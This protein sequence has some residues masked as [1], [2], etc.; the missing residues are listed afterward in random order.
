MSVDDWQRRL[1]ADPRGTLAELAQSLIEERPEDSRLEDLFWRALADH[2]TAEELARAVLCRLRTGVEAASEGERS[3]RR[4]VG[5]AAGPGLLDLDW[6]H[7]VRVHG[8]LRLAA[9]EAL[10]GVMRDRDERAR[11]EAH[12][13]RLPEVAF[14]RRG[15]P[16]EAAALYALEHDLLP[17]RSKNRLGAAAAPLVRGVLR[18]RLA[19]A[20]HRVEGEAERALAVTEGVLTLVGEPRESGEGGEEA[21]AES[22]PLRLSYHVR[23][24]LGLRHYEARRYRDAVRQFLQAAEAAPDTDLEL[25]AGIFAANALIRD[26]RQADA[27]RLLDSLRD[28]ASEVGSDLPDEWEAL[29]RGLTESEPEQ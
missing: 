1:R 7:Q 16:A 15:R 26:G 23:E 12:P 8:Q 18:Y 3:P 5:T 9:A 13:G 21:A 19:R 29:L 20:R 14:E 17:P 4:D 11:I 24:W 10:Q 22:L 2:G 25:A 27:R 28:R 6:E